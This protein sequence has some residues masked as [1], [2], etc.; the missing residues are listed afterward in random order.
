MVPTAQGRSALGPLLVRTRAAWCPGLGSIKRVKDT[1]GGIPGD[2]VASGVVTNQGG[3]K[4]FHMLGLHAENLP[5]ARQAPV[6][7]S[8]QKVWLIGGTC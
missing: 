7:R 3:M 6:G 8:E 2:P 5:K 4:T 1:G